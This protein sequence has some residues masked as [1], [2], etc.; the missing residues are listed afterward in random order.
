MPLVK[1]VPLTSDPGTEFHYSG[2]TP[3][4]LGATVARACDTD[5]K[6]F[7]QE[8]LFSPMDAEVGEW[9]MQLDG[10]YSGLAGLHISARDMAK[11]GLLYLNNGQYEGEQILST[12]YVRDSLQR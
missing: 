6:S 12:E 2:L 9:L 8:Y 3:H 7:A 1:E 10:Y 4:W 5:L 11:F